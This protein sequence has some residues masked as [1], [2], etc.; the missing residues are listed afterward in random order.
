MYS[1]VE[2]STIPK[3]MCDISQTRKGEN[4]LRKLKNFAKRGFQRKPEESMTRSGKQFRVE[5]TDNVT[6][7][8]TDPEH[9][10]DYVVCP[11]D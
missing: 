9:D 4:I 11:G 7:P 5:R 10:R 2:H 8:A 1:R 6:N 3:T